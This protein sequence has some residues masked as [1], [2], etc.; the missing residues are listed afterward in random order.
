VPSFICPT[1]A[2]CGNRDGPAP[3][4][5]AD[6]TDWI[7]PSQE[8]GCGVNTLKQ[9]GNSHAFGAGNARLCGAKA[10]SLQ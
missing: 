1:L 4:S 3:R 9:Q 7:S 10:I 8:T 6:H 2:A 5:R